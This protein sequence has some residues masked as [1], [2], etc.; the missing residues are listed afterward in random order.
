MTQDP[1]RP[2]EERDDEHVRALLADLPSGTEHPAMPPE[3]VARIEASLHEERRRRRAGATVTPLAT[4][5]RRA[6]SWLLG[7]AAAVVLVT[8]TG[9]VA[10]T[11]LRGGADSSAGSGAGG[12]AGDES[13]PASTRSEDGGL[14]DGDEGVEDAPSQSAESSTK[15]FSGNSGRSPF[16]SSSP[17]VLTMTERRYTEATLEEGAART[18]SVWT[19]KH[20]GAVPLSASSPTLGPLTTERGAR[21]CLRQI[22]AGEVHP[23]Q[24]DVGT[25]DG[26]AGF[27]LVAVGDDGTRAWAVAAGCEPIYDTSVPVR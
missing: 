18:T 19:R 17:F 24:A 6:G 27:L 8:G 15:A 3:L 21:D 13:G 5:R 9:Y 10:S 7:A 1:Q 26:R 4:H 11:T 25:F 22:G 14:T 16:Q 12:S 23:V 2:D 20:R